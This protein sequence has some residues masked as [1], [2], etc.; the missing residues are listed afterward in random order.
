M[1]RTQTLDTL[2]VCT[3]TSERRNRL[4]VTIPGLEHVKQ[5]GA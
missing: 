4:L 3:A 5:T 2:R 1:A